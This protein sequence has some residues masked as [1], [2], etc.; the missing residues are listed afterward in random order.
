MKNWYLIGVASGL[1]VGVVV[2]FLS[3]IKKRKNG[4]MEWDERQ[5]AER[6]NCLQIGFYTLII[7]NVFLALIPFV[8][9]ESI[10]ETPEMGNILA[11][12]IG[13][14]AFATTAIIKDA[15]FSIHE[16]KKSFYGIGTALALMCG[17]GSVRLMMED[18]MIVDGKISNRSLILFV[19]LLWVVLMVTAVIHSRK[20][21]KGE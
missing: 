15:Y 20:E 2:L 17:I 21:D 14:G 7:C 12:I 6:G 5:V 1:L 3:A 11:V 19:F 18:M 4:K 10:F 9:G 8:T 16:N 13:I